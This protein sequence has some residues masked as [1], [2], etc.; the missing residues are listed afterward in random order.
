MA[1]PKFDYY[2]P[3]SLKEANEMAVKSPGRYVFM[4][5]GT[6]VILLLKDGALPDVDT[7]IDLKK[8]PELERLEF[9]D[10]EGLRVGALTKLYAIQNSP[11]VNEKMPAVADAA[12]FVASAQIRRKGT[13]AGNICNASPSADTAPI[14]VAM[15]ASVKVWGAKGERTIPIDEFFTG[16][17][18][19]SLKKEEGE[20]VTEIDIP[21]LKP[22]E[23][24][25]YIKH[26]VRKAMDLAIIGSGVWV[27]MDGSRVADCR[28]AMGGVAVTPMRAKKAEEFL[29]GK[30]ASDENLAQAGQIAST[31]CHPISDVRASAEYRT[32]MIRVFTKRA[33]KKA[34]EHLA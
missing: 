1:L 34:L 8:I 3:E 25:A 24:S 2:A 29:I 31:E 30:E 23:G 20:I 13:M 16:V 26:S 7:V 28:I 10:E 14:L 9:S 33:L 11:V 17:K 15:N 21:A 22:G 4:A 6:D 27:K 12:H 32:D 5:G 19:T 18:K